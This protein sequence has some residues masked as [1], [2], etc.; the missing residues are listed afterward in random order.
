MVKKFI[1]W[2]E[3]KTGV[4]LHPRFVTSFGLLIFSLVLFG[5]VFF[6]ARLY[7]QESVGPQTEKER[8][9]YE[10]KMRIRV[11]TSSTQNPEE[12]AL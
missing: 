3:S 1:Y 12:N 5:I 11:P 7:T 9:E 4:Y 2:F 10:A 8:S 6:F